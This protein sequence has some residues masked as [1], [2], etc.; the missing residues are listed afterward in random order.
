M[1]VIY[2]LVAILTILLGLIDYVLL[3]DEHRNNRKLFVIIIIQFLAVVTMASMTYYITITDAQNTQTIIDTGNFNKHLGEQTQLLT[4]QIDS[5]QS[6]DDSIMKHSDSLSSKIDS[7]SDISKNL[8]YDIN[9]VIKEQSEENAI[10]GKFD[11]DMGKPLNGD[12]MITVHFGSMTATNTILPVP[13]V[14]Y[15]AGMHLIVLPDSSEPITFGLENHKLTVSLDI[16]DLNGNLMVSI[17][18]NNWHRYTNNTGIFNYDKNGFEIF[19]NKGNIAL[20]MDL[21][22][23]NIVIQGYVFIRKYNKMIIAGSYIDIP[24]SLDMQQTQNY[25][26]EEVRRVR[27]K[28]LFKYTGTHWLHKRM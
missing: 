24:G 26:A 13:N 7:V 27:I 1:G 4:K 16:Y 14:W 23:N 15:K 8:A 10:T 3:K 6:L 20:S 21:K 18:K 22:G 17:D 25:L 11:F 28:Q 12:D 19:D 2:A 5:L 9:S